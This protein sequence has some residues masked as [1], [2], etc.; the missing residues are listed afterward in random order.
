M[1]ISLK[2]ISGRWWFFIIV[3]IF[4]F[5]AI[6]I[7]PTLLQ[8]SLIFFGKILLKITPILLIV[9]FFM[10]LMNR[11]VSRQFIVGYLQKKKRKETWLIAIISGILSAGAIYMWY[12]LLADL[13]K[14]GIDYGLIACFLYNRA[15]KIPLL[16]V[17][18][19][20][21]G[22]KYVIILTI[23][24]IITSVIQGLIVNLLVKDNT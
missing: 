1:K 3:L 14:K 18:I 21:F 15:I 24:M 13:H 11:F 16:P 19:Y 23:L 17:A 5:G 6:L 4:Y 8:G 12:P 22:W 10:A 9:W 7:Q 20:Y 2:S